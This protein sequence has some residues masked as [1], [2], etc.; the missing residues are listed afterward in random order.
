MF[1]KGNEKELLGIIAKLLSTLS[2]EGLQVE[3]NEDIVNLLSDIHTK[4]QMFSLDADDVDTNT[5]R[6]IEAS[7]SIVVTA[8]SSL[9]S[10]FAG[11]SRTPSLDIATGSGSVTSGAQSVTIVTSS[12][13]SGTI[14][15]TSVSTNKAFTWSSK[16]N[17]TLAAIAYTISAGSLTILQIR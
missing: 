10:Y 13:F 6:V 5:L 4:L 3:G 17:D 7:D 1:I 9:S 11:T 2:V 12:D 8:L 15:G 14:L 16:L